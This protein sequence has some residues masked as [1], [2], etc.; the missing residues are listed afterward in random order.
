MV[1]QPEG[2]PKVDAQQAAGV[3][4][5]GNNV[6]HNYF[7]VHPPARRARSRRRYR[8]GVV[9]SLADCH[10]D[11]QVDGVLAASGT[12]MPC[13]VLVG[14]GGVGK[15]QLAAGLARRLWE[16]QKV[17]V[18]IWVTATSRTDIQTRYRHAA[19]DV[20]GFHDPD[21]EEAAVRFLSWLAATDLRW[22]VVLDD[23]TDPVDMVG[24]WPPE[25]TSGR[26][27]VTTRRRDAALLA[28]R[29]QV[30]VGLYTP[31]E[32][33][34]YLHAKLDGAPERLEEAE[35][36]AADL[37][38]LPLALAQASAY[39]VDQG[40]TCASY[41]Q[42]LAQRRLADVAPDVL[43]DEH[44]VALSVTW[45]L[46]V[47]LADQL[48]PQKVARPVLE[49]SSLLDPNAIPIALFATTAVTSYCTTRAARR[50]DTDHAHIGPACR[51]RR[52][53]SCL[54]AGSCQNCRGRPPRNLA[55]QRT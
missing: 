22:L 44:A 36:L 13:Q 9:P 7:Y 39:I 5:G 18:L 28:G 11:R 49:L 25:S 27:V 54:H 41:R 47:D 40:L 24:L 16:K 35:A 6:Q 2:L 23:L 31:S 42:R 20:A 26:T 1:T 38:Y 33:L 48:A 45:S 52:H 19:A 29:Q 53:S 32:A 37:Q 4:A 17:E 51:A 10:Q 12:S 34:L 3:Q 50:V 55:R 14:P 30:D 15:T 46:S 21:P 8:S 43:P